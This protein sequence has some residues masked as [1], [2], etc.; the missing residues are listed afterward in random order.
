MVEE[1][2]DKL[3]SFYE[4]VDD[5]ALPAVSKALSSG[6]KQKVFNKRPLN[7]NGHADVSSEKFNAAVLNELR[8]T[9]GPDTS[10]SSSDDSPLSS[11]STSS[12][13]H[14]LELNNNGWFI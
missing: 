10:G 4:I 6:L 3:G 8:V 14:R 7:G 13:E 9:T 12:E 2:V 11:P 1:F 5:G